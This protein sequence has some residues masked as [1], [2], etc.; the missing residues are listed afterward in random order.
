MPWWKLWIALAGV[1]L[2]ARLAIAWAVEGPETPPGVVLARLAVVPLAQTAA[3]GW[4]LSFFRRR[5]GS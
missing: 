1:Y 3:A 2:A 4:A 5:S